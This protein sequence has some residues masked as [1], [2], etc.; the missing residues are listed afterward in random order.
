MKARTVFIMCASVFVTDTLMQ[1][2]LSA[3]L[4]AFFAFAHLAVRP[5]DTRILNVLE[6]AGLVVAFLVQILSVSY[7]RLPKDSAS[8]TVFTMTLVLLV[9]SFLLACGAV[10]VHLF[11]TTRRT[12]AHLANALKLDARFSGRTSGAAGS[13]LRESRRNG[14]RQRGAVAAVN[15]HRHASAW[16]A[17]ARKSTAQRRGGVQ[18]HAGV[19]LVDVS[20]HPLLLPTRRAG[21]RGAIT[22]DDGLPTG[23]GNG[24]PATARGNLRLKVPTA[25]EAQRREAPRS[26]QPAADTAEKPQRGHKPGSHR[27]AA[28]PTGAA[29]T[30]PRSSSS[31]RS[32]TASRGRRRGRTRSHPRSGSHSSHDGEASAGRHPLTS[33]ASPAPGSGSPT[34]AATLGVAGSTVHHVA[35][36]QAHDPRRARAGVGRTCG[37]GGGQPQGAH[38]VSQWR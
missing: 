21:R 4:I 25:A 27:G 16:L 22:L 15:A 12:Q 24:G 10:G 29:T 30:K 35:R 28:S 20:V 31:P 17:R 33:P 19:E 2:V 3:A 8:D 9:V 11:L 13:G 18:S 6:A 26:L 32:P 7:W 34:V 1:V 37:R 14:A 38:H 23:A 5:F 36:R